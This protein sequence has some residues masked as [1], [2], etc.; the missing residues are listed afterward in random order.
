MANQLNWISNL[1]HRFSVLINMLFDLFFFLFLVSVGPFCQLLIMLE[2]PSLVVAWLGWWWW[3]RILQLSL[4]PTPMTTL[5]AMRPHTPGRK[6]YFS[7]CI[8]FAL[9][10]GWLTYFLPHE[11]LAGMWVWGW[12]EKSY[13]VE[14]KGVIFEEWNNVATFEYMWQLTSSKID[15]RK[16]GEMCVRCKFEWNSEFFHVWMGG[17]EARKDHL[18]AC[19]GSSREWMQ[20]ISRRFEARCKKASWWLSIGRGEYVKIKSLPNFGSNFGK[21]KIST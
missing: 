8:F 10:G 14:R 20:G 19:R 16:A 5:E 4:R 2:C 6:M 12:K 9:L 17:F 21:T 7:F 1:H 11:L 15:T 13:F 3:E 18:P